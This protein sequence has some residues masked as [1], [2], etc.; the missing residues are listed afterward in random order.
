MFWKLFRESAYRPLLFLTLAVLSPLQTWSQS[1]TASLQGTVQDQSRAFIPAAGIT[2]E[3]EAT[4][5]RQTT[6]TDENGRYFI[7]SLPPGSYKLTVEAPGFQTSIRTGM[8]LQVQQRAN[9]DVTLTTGE[10]N[11]SVT[12]SGEAPRL[13]SVTATL[14]RVVES[15]S[16]LSMPLGSRNTLDLAMLT[17]GVSG[18]SG[19]TG[20]NFASN[21]TRNSQADVLIDG[22]TVSVQ[23]QNGGVTDAKFRPS[24]EAVQ[25]M[26]VMTNS[27][28]AEYGNT[29]GTVVTMVTRSGTND[30]HGSVFEFLRNSALNA[31]NFF[32]NRS[33]RSLVPFRRNQFGGAVGGPVYLPKIYNGRDRTFFFFH[34]EATR[35][36][37]QTTT[38][39]TVPSLRERL[40]DFSDTRD[41]AGRLI[42]IYD[43]ATVRTNPQTGNPV[44]DAFP[45]NIIPANRFDPV[46]K[47]ALQ[48]YPAPN[49]PGNAFTRL[50]NFF[51]AGSRTTNDYQTTI[52]I[53]HNFSAA[54]RFSARYSQYRVKGMSP[55]LWGNWMNPFDDGPE[56]PGDI[57]RN[58]SADYT[59]TLSPTTVLNLRWG[60]ARQYGVRV[61]FCEQCPEFDIAAFGFQGPMNTQIPPNFQPESY[62]ALGTRPQARVR[63]GED[64]NHFVGNL[65]KLA[66]GHT[67]KFGG[68]ARIFR[69]N[70]A[71]PGWNSVSFNFNRLTTSQDPFRG[72]SLQGNAIAS[73]LLGWGNSGQQ[74]TGAYSS[75]ASTSYGLFFQDDWRV[76]RK[77]TFNLG[78]RYELDMPRTERYDRVSWVD[79]NVISPVRAPGLP[80]LRGGLVFADENNRAPFDTD[81]NNFAPRFGF[82]YTFHP[83]FVAR[84]GYGIYYGISAA[85]NRSQLGQGFNTSTPWNTSLDGGATQYASLSNPFRDGIDVPPGSSQGLNTLVGRGISGPIRSWG[86]KPYYQQ[87]SFSIQR[88]LPA[89]SVFEI[90]YFGNRGVHLY[91]GNNTALNRIDQQYLSLGPGLN[92]LVPNPF[93]NVI[94]DPLSVLSKPTVTRGQLLRPYP[95]FTSI[96]GVTGPPTAN[97]IYHAMQ[98]QFTKRYSHGVSLS[99]H[100]TFSK[101]IDDDSLTGGLGWLGYDTGGVQS[102]SNLRLER[103]VSV[104]DRTHRAVVDFAYELPFGKGKAFGSGLP[105]WVD[106]IAGGWQANGIISLQSGAPL[107]P[108]L[109]G[110]VLPDARQRPNLLRD[111]GVSAPVTDRLNAYLDPSAFSRPQPYTLGTAPRTISSVRAPAS[112]NMDASLFKNLYLTG[113]RRVYLQLRGEAFNITNTPIFA[114]PD[115]NFGSTSFGVISS[116]A[117]GPRQIQVAMKLY[118]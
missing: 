11:T 72:D 8:T 48:F 28:S 77:L 85:Q 45:G 41:S 97:S 61:P 14:G 88:E 84:G 52:K 15:A 37:S 36:S 44:R 59:H 21:G 80:E 68:E 66:G 18:T 102:Y 49:Q 96:S 110:G 19:F 111:P 67:L 76:T 57:T 69:L 116:Q 54:Q 3:N 81:T 71:Q 62:Q 34:Y 108:A 105:T 51:N 39:T 26:K 101:M 117:N 1:Y 118:F 31:N 112:R 25:E 9:V 5:V 91:Y 17:P 89:N 13:D 16:V 64:V 20:T 4:N 40:G 75:F 73:M 24:V 74:S 50:N 87:W 83:K 22:T 10:V 56:S 58:G 98:L 7:A 53:D 99:G 115:M 35:Q 32:A 90:A 46:A 109:N 106:W 113:D 27:F 94:T 23:E 33:G 93:F 2:V 86:S 42:T 55:D 30:L 78:L 92:D 103:A 63:R 70:Y 65:S 60:V 100:Y 114:A 79:P 47:Y 82:A 104:Y 95:Q 12:V 38:L 43:P 107:V 6:S 29:G